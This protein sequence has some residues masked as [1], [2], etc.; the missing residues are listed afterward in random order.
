MKKKTY[1]KTYIKLWYK[2]NW[3]FIF[4]YKNTKWLDGKLYELYDSLNNH[5]YPDFNK[6]EKSKYNSTYSSNEFN[7]I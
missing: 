4:D 5:L 3:I 6:F 7:F 1:I 2:K